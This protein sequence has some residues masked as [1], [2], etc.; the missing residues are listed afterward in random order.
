MVCCRVNFA[1]TFT[2]VLGALSFAVKWCGYEGDCSPV[3]R[4]EVKNVWISTSCASYAFVL[5][6]FSYAQGQLSSCTMV[7]IV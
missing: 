3:S 1:V 4:V 7:L 5:W 6:V 2:L